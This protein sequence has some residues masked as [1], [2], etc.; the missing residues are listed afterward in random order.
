M[1]P[2]AGAADDL[3]FPAVARAATL[4][5]K[6]AAEVTRTIVDGVLPAGA[7]LPSERELGEQFG[8]SRTV[9]RE[10]VRSLAAAGLIETRIGARP[11][12]AQ[13]GS[14][15]VNRALRMFLQRSEVDYRRVHEV[16]TA[17]EIE[18][19]GYA[20]E[21]ATADDLERLGDLNDEL[22][23]ISGA[24]IDRAA[25]LDVAF[26][27][28]IAGATGNTLFSVLLEAIEPVLLEVRRRAFREARMREYALSAHE[29]ILRSIDAGDPE[30]AR[31]AMR[32]HLQAAES[33]WA[34]TRD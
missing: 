2:K 24:A 18:I 23:S 7:A 29:Q 32:A 17:L 3:A 20:A 27:Q 5:E 25:E 10:A 12:V 4:S 33:A 31:Q 11:R 16:R 30:G 13:V 21:R 22:A 14:D 1:R 9:I 15:G 34:E 8:V 26:H 6:V 28:A 19:A